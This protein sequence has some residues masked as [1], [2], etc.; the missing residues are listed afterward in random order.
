MESL[1]SFVPIS[2]DFKK[3]LAVTKCLSLGNTFV[4]RR[5]SSAIA[6]VNLEVSE[7]LCTNTPRVAP[8][9]T[10]QIAERSEAKTR[11]LVSMRLFPASLE[12]FPWREL[13]C[14]SNLLEGVSARTLYE[15]AAAF[16]D[17]GLA[18][19]G[20][21]ETERKEDQAIVDWLGTSFTKRVS[22]WASKLV[23]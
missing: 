21:F 1:L 13:L 16:F 10:I 12:S 22:A 17:C 6:P 15:S 8:Y 20:C 4:L 3:P 9:D 19:L 14:T 11:V 7:N 2:Y 5:Y 23:E 18:P